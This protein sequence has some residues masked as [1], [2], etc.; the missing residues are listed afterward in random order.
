MNNDAM[1]AESVLEKVLTKGGE[2]ARKHIV[3][4][5]ANIS[6]GAAK[7]AYLE[8]IKKAGGNSFNASNLPKDASEYI[9][10]YGGMDTS[11]AANKLVL[12]WITDKE[13][14][15]HKEDSSCFD[16]MEQLELSAKNFPAQSGKTDDQDSVKS[17]KIGWS[18]ADKRC[19][20]WWT[21]GTEKGSSGY[22]NETDVDKWIKD[23]VDNKVDERLN[24]LFAA[25]KFN[26]SDLTALANETEVRGFLALKPDPNNSNHYSVD[27]IFADSTG[28]KFV[29]ED[30]VHSIP[31]CTNTNKGEFG[32]LIDL[33]LVSN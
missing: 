14:V 4:W 2:Q 9:H 11:G 24:P 10:I 3:A 22:L 32:A 16:K 26:K 15:A 1:R 30:V 5:N 23:K 28:T 29:L 17:D 31:P 6:P 18:T 19:G 7:K 8:A 21:S 27:V 33:G 12:Y 25:M 20:N 13:D